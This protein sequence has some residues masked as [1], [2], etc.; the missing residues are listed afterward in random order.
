MFDIVNTAKF[1]PDPKSW[2][3]VEY[4]GSEQEKYLIFRYNLICI[5]L[6]EAIF[7]TC[8]KFH[9]DICMLNAIK[10]LSK[11]S[12]DF[13]FPLSTFTSGF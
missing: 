4:F 12:P 3:R 8:S 11:F 2:N 5:V 7:Y 6:E 13:W 9:P 10:R 1:G